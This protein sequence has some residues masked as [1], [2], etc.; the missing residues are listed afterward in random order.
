MGISPFRQ[1]AEV[2]AQPSSPW[3]DGHGADGR[4]AVMPVPGF[5]NRG[6]DSVSS[7][8]ARTIRK[9]PP[10]LAAQGKRVA[11]KTSSQTSTEDDPNLA[12]VVAAWPELPEAIRAGIV[13]MARAALPEYG[14][15]PRMLQDKPMGS[16]MGVSPPVRRTGGSPGRR[17]GPSRRCL[18]AILDRVPPDPREPPPLRLDREEPRWVRRRRSRLIEAADLRRW[19]VCGGA[20]RSPAG[21]WPPSL[22]APETRARERPRSGPGS[23]RWGSPPCGC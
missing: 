13:A 11:S 4:D 1:Q 16:G 17:E 18:R 10:S 22:P 6:D 12:A 2:Q 15:G 7:E 19:P 14:E 9:L 21:P 3:A 20:S 23:R 5:R 8:P